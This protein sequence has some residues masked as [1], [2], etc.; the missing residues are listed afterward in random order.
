MAVGVNPTA[1]LLAC[2]LCTVVD[3]ILA[4]WSG[5]RRR[6]LYGPR[7]EGAEEERDHGEKGRERWTEALAQQKRMERIALSKRT[8]EEQSNGLVIISA[9]Y[10]A[11]TGD[12]SILDVTV[13]AQFWTNEGSLWMPPGR[14]GGLLG[15]CDVGTNERRQRSAE[16]TATLGLFRFHWVRTAF[17]QW[18]A[19]TASTDDE[20]SAMVEAPVLHVRYRLG[21]KVYEA[22]VRDDE[23]VYISPSSPVLAGGTV[24]GDAN[25]VLA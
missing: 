10:S 19:T 18:Q 20:V 8:K 6:L 13:P 1:M 3:D 2:A 11:G 9:T 23:A 7:K 14:R 5:R 21:G 22:S 15:F 17:R 25:V 24:V 4:D 12:H 16:R